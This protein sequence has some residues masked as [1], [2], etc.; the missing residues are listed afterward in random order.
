M[1]EHYAVDDSFLPAIELLN[2]CEI[3]IDITDDYVHLF[4]GQRDFSWKRGCPDIDGA[5]TFISVEGIPDK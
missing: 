2:P 1:R 3:R 4:V 5:G